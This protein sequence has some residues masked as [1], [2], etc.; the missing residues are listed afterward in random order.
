MLP[1]QST[2][3]MK[4]QRKNRRRGIRVTPATTVMKVRTNGTK[5]PITSALL[6]CLSKNTRVWSKY[7]CLSKPA[8]ALVERW[9]DR[10]ADLVADDVAE[11]GRAGQQHEGQHQLEAL[12]AGEQV[13]LPGGDEQPEREEQ[14]VPGQEREEQPALDEDDDQADPEELG[15]E[16]VEQP[17]GVHPVHAEQVRHDHRGPGHG[18]T[19]T[20]G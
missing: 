17:V 18:A 20:G 15:A 3:P 19:L 1:T 4:L 12:A 10:A 2:A 9:P 11:E 6:P 14:G 5:R 7:F 16:P 8:V 13:D